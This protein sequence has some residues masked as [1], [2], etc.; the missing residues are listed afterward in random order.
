[1]DIFDYA[2]MDRSKPFSTTQANKKEHEEVVDL[3]FGS[4]VKKA[5]NTRNQEVQDLT[6]DEDEDNNSSDGDDKD[7][8]AKKKGKHGKGQPR[9]KKKAET[10]TSSQWCKKLGD[11]AAP[12]LDDIPRGIH[13]VLINT[14]MQNIIRIASSVSV[15]TTQVTKAQF[16]AELF[17]RSNETEAS[18]AALKAFCSR[19][20]K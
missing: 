7:G 18:V 5:K 1:M 15:C 20:M 2:Q 10:L 8:D 6:S 17:K 4:V 19:L 13:A 16:L 3:T 12:Y 9:K 11:I 14:V